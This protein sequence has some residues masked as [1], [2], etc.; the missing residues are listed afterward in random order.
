MAH[1]CNCGEC[2]TH[3]LAPVYKCQYNLSVVEP[4]LRPVEWLGDSRERVRAFP[5][6]AREDVG[7]QLDRVQRGLDPADWRPMPLV[8]VGVIEIRVHA[9]S[10][11]RVFY[12]ARFKH[13]V[14][15]LHAF[16][17]KTPR[18]AARDTVLARRRYHDL[19]RRKKR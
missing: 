9:G 19:L 14:Y 17:K 11:Y 15:I 16:V 1:A 4:V 10:E 5:R 7:F 8:G 2:K 13:A 6:S 18:T 12:L 3:I